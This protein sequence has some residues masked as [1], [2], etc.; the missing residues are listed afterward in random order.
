M[1]C[2]NGIPEK[3]RNVIQLVVLATFHNWVISTK[4]KEMP[5]LHVFVYTILLS[6]FY[7][8]L[9]LTW[10]QQPTISVPFKR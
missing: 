4:N 2:C 1:F 3:R 6:P 8:K 10:M 7:T 9:Y 5:K